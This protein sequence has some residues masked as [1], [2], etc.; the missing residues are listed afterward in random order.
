[1]NTSKFSLSLGLHRFSCFALVLLLSLFGEVVQAKDK[2]VVVST[3]IQA[4]VDAA[5]A[6]D[7]V[8]V[9]PGLY[10]ENVLV[11]KNNITIKGS[12]DA[13]LDGT[14]L[15]GDSGITV[16]S[17]TPSLRI[18]E[19]TLTGLRIQNYSG[20]GVI[21]IRVDKFQIDDGQYVNNDQYGIFPILSSHGRVEFNQVSGS[22]DTGIYVGQSEDI[23]VSQNS[24]SNCTIG[25]EVEN[26]S[27]ISV[28]ENKATGN[29]LGVVVVV[30]PGLDVTATREVKVKN[31][32]LNRNNRPNPVTDPTDILSRLPSG[33]GLAIVG[34]DRVVAEQNQAVHNDSGGIG[35][36]QLPPDLVAL[37]PRINPLP[38]HD[39]I[40]ENVVISNGRNPDPK[41]LALGVQGADL[42]WD[43]SGTG[44]CWGDNVYKTSF[45]TPL[46]DC[47]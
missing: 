22:N 12:P 18:K 39:K 41:L 20:N 37:D 3:T 31:N 44:N 23:D 6:G 27:R 5:N 4:A 19:F 34:G 43:S 32:I 11:T 7:T 36:I 1:M 33:V 45:P 38:D 42:I 40:R 46:P 9:P 21:L 30:L 2:V 29:S 35:V 14:G 17:S 15:P 10:H 8:R 47:P 13:I 16:R 25:I 24:S 28:T 26:S